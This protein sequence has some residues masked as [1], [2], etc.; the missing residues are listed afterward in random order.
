MSSD[1]EV[2]FKVVSINSVPHQTRLWEPERADEAIFSSAVVFDR[3][4]A[5]AAR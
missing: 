5:S 4:S 1:L 3:N 2:A